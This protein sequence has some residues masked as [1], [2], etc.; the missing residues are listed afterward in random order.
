V[1]TEIT[2]TIVGGVLRPDEAL[3]LPEHTRVR[4]TIETIDDPA[5]SAVAWQALKERL[6][7]RPVHAGGQRFSRDELHERR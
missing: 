6:R 5:E 4:V 2:A 1:K 7:R 3:A